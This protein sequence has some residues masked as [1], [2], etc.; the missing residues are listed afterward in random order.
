MFSLKQI[1]NAVLLHVDDDNDVDDLFET[2]DSEDEMLDYKKVFSK[3]KNTTQNQSQQDS[4]L[5]QQ[6]QQQQQENQQKEEPIPYQPSSSTAVTSPNN[7][8]SFNIESK[9]DN[10]STSTHTVTNSSKSTGA[11]TATGT[12][13]ALSSATSIS[14]IKPVQNLDILSDNMKHT[15][16]INKTINKNI[17]KTINKTIS[18]SQLSGSELW[19]KQ[20]NEWLKPTSTKS[21]IEKRKHSR[22]LG[23]LVQFNDN[24]Y[25]SVYR[26]LVLYN[27]P[28]KNG[29]NMKDGFKVIY[30]GWENSKMFDRV[31]NGGVP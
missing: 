6:Q 4:H 31:A 25:L 28:L 26:N 20:R 19:E 8:T 18:Q 1:S 5:Q 7:S 2:I 11:G 13:T 16:S 15:E 24:V 22:S 14:N 12:V 23:K 30:S 9:S 3:V 21:D 27:K 10:T 29:I 17:N